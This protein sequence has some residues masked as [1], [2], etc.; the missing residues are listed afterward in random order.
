MFL[1]KHFRQRLPN[2]GRLT[3][4]QLRSIATPTLLLL[5]ENTKI[6]DPG[7]RSGPDG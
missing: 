6:Y 2:P 4:E 5:A 7:W 1:F 3:E